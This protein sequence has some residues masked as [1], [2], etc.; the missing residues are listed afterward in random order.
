MT[1]D[2]PGVPSVMYSP[3]PRLTTADPANPLAGDITEAMGA[4]APDTARP[5]RARRRAAG[6]RDER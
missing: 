3:A 5:L 6:V 4:I 1:V 2:D